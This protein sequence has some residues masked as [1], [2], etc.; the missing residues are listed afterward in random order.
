M[1]LIYDIDMVV[2]RR[3]TSLVVGVEG[4]LSGVL[5][6]GELRVRVV[7]VKLTLLKVLRRDHIIPL[8]IEFEQ[9]ALARHALG[10]W[11]AL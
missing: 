5:R 8:L 11:T 7:L 1:F 9:V 10:L 3:F 6:G 2:P 4:C